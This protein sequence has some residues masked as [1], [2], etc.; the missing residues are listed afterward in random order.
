MCFAPKGEEEPRAVWVFLKGFPGAGVAFVLVLF[1]IQ[2]GK[3]QGRAN[4]AL[5]H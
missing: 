5:L 3:C 1:N 4:L 2:F